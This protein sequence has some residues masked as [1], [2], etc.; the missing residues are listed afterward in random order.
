[1]PVPPFS[2]NPTVFVFLPVISTEFTLMNLQTEVA[3]VEAIM[4]N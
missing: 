1:M 4:T 3:D 2:A